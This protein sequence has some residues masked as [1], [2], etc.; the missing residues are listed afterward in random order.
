MCGVVVLVF[1]AVGLQTTR[2]GSKQL[3]KQKRKVRLPRSNFLWK[4][5]R[6]ALAVK[7]CCEAT[8]H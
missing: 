1:V 6:A 3:R 2:A 7:V 5:I 4:I 8:E